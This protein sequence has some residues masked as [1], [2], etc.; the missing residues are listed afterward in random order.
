VKYEHQKPIQILKHK[1]RFRSLKRN[2]EVPRE[3]KLFFFSA[4]KSHVTKLI[5]FI[6]LR[7]KENFLNINLLASRTIVLLPSFFGRVFSVNYAF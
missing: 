2:K 3:K 6:I 7:N 4:K 5:E 1:I